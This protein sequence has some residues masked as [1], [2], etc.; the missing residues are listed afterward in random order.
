MIRYEIQSNVSG[1]WETIENGE[2]ESKEA[3]NSALENLIETTKWNAETLRV[4]E[5]KVS[6]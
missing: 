1:Q 4:K 6:P 2:F 3:A 5:V